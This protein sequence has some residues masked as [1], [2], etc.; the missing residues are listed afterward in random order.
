MAGDTSYDCICNEDIRQRFSI[1]TIADKL[2]DSRNGWCS[3]VPRTDDASFCKI[4]SR[5]I[6]QAAIRR[7]EE[8]MARH[9]PF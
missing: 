7:T 2:R 9:V 5:C 4:Q 1:G 8:T 6:Q 3:H